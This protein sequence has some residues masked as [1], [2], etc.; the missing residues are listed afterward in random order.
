MVACG[1]AGTY[2]PV[3]V[4]GKNSWEP[5]VFWSLTKCLRPLFPRLIPD[6][7]LIVQGDF[8]WMPLEDF[9]LM[10]KQVWDYYGRDVD[11]AE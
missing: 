2:N 3:V 7:P 1:K 5:M 9:I 8:R 4:L 6:S 10:L 11:V